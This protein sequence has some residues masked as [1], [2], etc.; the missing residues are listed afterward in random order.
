MRVLTEHKNT[1]TVGD[2]TGEPTRS[3][4]PLLARG[5]WLATVTFTL[6]VFFVS[7]PLYLAQMQ[8]PCAGTACSYQQL[9]AG[10]ANTL[11]T[12]GLS[13]RGYSF[14]IVALMML[15][16]AV[17]LGVSAVIIW[18]RSNDWMAVLVALMLVTLGP[19]IGTATLITSDAVLQVANECVTYLDLALF[20]VVFSLFPSGRFVPGWLRWPLG[21]LLILEIPLT[22]LPSTAIMPNVSV[23]QPG[24]LVTLVG[25]A[26]VALAQFYRYRRVSSAVQRQQTKVVVVGLAVPISVLVVISVLPPLEPSLTNHSPVFLLVVNSAGILLSLFVPLAFGFAILRYRLWD[27]DAIINKALV[28]GS[29]TALLAG[30]Y[31]ALVIGLQALAGITT[32]H[33]AEQPVALV[34]STLATVALI[35]PLRRRL[36]RV[37]DQ[38]FYRR[39]YNAEK[40]LAAF[41]AALRSEVDLNDLS[42][43]LLAMV[44]ETMEPAHI[45]L[46]LSRRP[47]HNAEEARR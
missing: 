42:R 24:W 25:F 12:I 20:L 14:L 45:S 26:M 47:L 5:L 11:A 29:L 23:S 44:Q 30:V 3:P 13:L 46:W 40:M 39:K 4:Q 2:A 32:G 19:I 6:I 36:Q 28:Y 7:L 21:A 1:P 16:S 41:T 22:F 37:I 31:A 10:Q 35:Q 8:T 33:F 18:R 15:A 27:I 34:I 17:C 38:R 9:T 43:D